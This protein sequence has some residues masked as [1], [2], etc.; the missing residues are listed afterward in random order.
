MSFRRALVCVPF[1][2]LALGCGGVDY[3]T[4]GHVKGTVTTSAPDPANKT[5]T[6]RV[7]L[8]SGT[9][10]FHGPNGITASAHVNVKGEYDMPDAP[11]GDCQVTVTVANL[12]MD[13]S[14]KARLTGKG[15]GPKMPEMKNPDA[16]PTELPSA[17]EVPKELV[18]IDAKFGKPESSGLKF[19]VIKGET[20]VFPIDL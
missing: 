16:G 3:K 1:L 2:A 17:P 12:P 11:I 18:R 10:M 9:V 20:H 8:T 6:K 14:V 19:T 7:P 4:R 13:P 5:K 15:G